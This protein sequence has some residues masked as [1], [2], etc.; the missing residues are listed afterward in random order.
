[1]SAVATQ[2]DADRYVDGAITL[3]EFRRRVR[4]RYGVVKKPEV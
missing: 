3:A 1:M 2:A 4:E